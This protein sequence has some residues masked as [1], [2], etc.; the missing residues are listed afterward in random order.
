MAGL[1][2][3]WHQ[4]IPLGNGLMGAMVWS[5]DGHLRLSIDRADLWDLSYIREF[6]LDEWNFSWVFQ[7]WVKA[8]E[9]GAVQQLF[10]QPYYRDPAP[11]RLPAGAVTL[12]LFSL[13]RPDSVSLDLFRGSCRLA[14][15]SGIAMSIFVHASQHVG[16]FRITGLPKE[17]APALSPHNFLLVRNRFSTD[18]VPIGWQQLSYPLPVMRV[19]KQRAY[20][21]QDASQGISW[22]MELQWKYHQ[23]TLDAAWSVA[24][25]YPGGETTVP[26]WD[27]VSHFLT[28][29]YDSLYRTHTGWWQRYWMQ[30]ALHLP[31]SAMQRQWEMGQ[32]LTG[33]SFRKDAPPPSI[34]GLW[35]NDD[36]QLPYDK[37]AYH[38]YLHTQMCAWPCY[39]GNRLAEAAVLTD[40][41][42]LYKPVAE[43]YTRKYF[44][45]DGLAFPGVSAFNAYPLGG[46]AP[47]AFSPT[48]S[49]WLGHH[50]Y[51]QWKYSMDRNFLQH[52]A[53]P[54]VRDVALFLE[55]MSVF[56]PDSSRCLLMSSSPKT[57]GATGEAWFGLNTNYDLA[58][59]RALHTAACEMAEQLGLE[60]DLQ[61]WRRNLDSWPEPAVD[62]TFSR[63]MIAPGV[64]P[65][66]HHSY[67]SHLVAVYPLGL[68]DAFRDERTA[69][70]VKR[71]LD[72]LAPASD[73]SWQAYGLAWLALLRARAG[74]G[75][76]ARAALRALIRGHFLANG[77]A[78]TEKQ[79]DRQETLPLSPE[80]G[81]GFNAA[82][83]EMLLQGHHGIIRLFPAIP[84]EWKNVSFMKLRTEGAFLVSAAMKQGLVSSVV[85]LSEKGGVMRMANPFGTAA[86]RISGARAES[87]DDKEI[88]VHTRP[89]MIM[90]F[91]KNE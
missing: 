33:A 18:T 74:Q 7:R 80:A 66:P 89:G 38:H 42:W 36:G 30:A 49:A 67:L 13:G 86:V 65:D 44:G 8:G 39:S 62:S 45:A 77:L 9:Y 82:V 22:E 14:W 51:W 50:F 37:N 73:A 88:V 70:L 34:L 47:W 5:G 19:E 53:Y 24:V 48:V 2:A 76:E 35:T 68:I 23:D 40:W 72:D 31:D 61:R 60:D 10:D 64:L 69:S 83:Q 81:M 21:H 12:D 6:D 52:R 59:I 17:I 15:N 91:T 4:G 90:Q 11:V 87:L 20:F 32:Y 84:E 29:G 25:H 1:P 16:M 41:L 27:M 55:K 26:V 79:K 58:L 78:V 46:G 75:N 54:W 57:G 28:L 85:V 56:L 43:K 71:S 3:A 63:L